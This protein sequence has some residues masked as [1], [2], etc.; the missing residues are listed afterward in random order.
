MSVKGWVGVSL[1]WVSGEEGWV[2]IGS[3]DDVLVGQDG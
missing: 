2:G 3:L 1:E